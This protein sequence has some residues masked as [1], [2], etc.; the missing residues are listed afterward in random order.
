M[1]IAHRVNTIERVYY[2][3]HL[4]NIEAI[5]IDIQPTL[6]GQI[7]VYH[8]DVSSMNYSDLPSYVPTFE[9]FLRFIPEKIFVNV[10]VKKYEKSSSIITDVIGLCEKYPREYIFSSF[11]KDTY[12]ACVKAGKKC[13]HLQDTMAKYNSSI[14]NIC[15]H[16]SMLANMS[17]K[18]HEMIAV[19]DVSETSVDE[20]TSTYPFVYAWITDYQ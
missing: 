10:E 9:E 11:D 17:Q 8:D 20:F 2:L 6:D 14:P 18:D 16:A 15:I 5:E 1:H 3:Y 4:K 19:Y 12:D 13:W 7:V